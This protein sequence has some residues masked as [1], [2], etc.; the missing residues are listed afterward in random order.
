MEF[1]ICR[2]ETVQHAVLVAFSE[3]GFC[4]RGDLC[5]FDHGTD[6]VVL[7]DVGLSHVLSYG[8][9][10]GP[11]GAAP[12]AMAGV[13]VLGKAPA[14]VAVSG[15]AAAL[16]G[17]GPPMAAEMAPSAP[18]AQVPPPTLPM[19]GPPPTHLAPPFP[20]MNRFQQPPPPPPPV[21]G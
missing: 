21:P 5:Q 14:G 8:P 2:K 12:T 20:P 6:P 1:D 9:G 19:M 16:P 7:E 10:P 13:P 4:M 3:K 15:G 18:Q 17:L 11:N